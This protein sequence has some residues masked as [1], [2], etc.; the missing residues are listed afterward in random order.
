MA[1]H[2][3]CEKRTMIKVNFRFYLYKKKKDIN[4]LIFKVH[5]DLHY[6]KETLI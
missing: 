4:H 1:A 6:L 3:Y 5:K 2:A